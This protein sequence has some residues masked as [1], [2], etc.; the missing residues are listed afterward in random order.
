MEDDLE[1]L[2]LIKTSGVTR[3]I[4]ERRHIIAYPISSKRI[5]NISTTQPDIDFAIS[6]SETC[7]TKGSKSIML[8]GLKIST[9]KSNL[10][11]HAP[12]PTWARGCMALVGDACHL[13]LPRLTQ[14]AAQ[15]LEDERWWRCVWDCWRMDRGRE[16]VRKKRAENAVELAA[17]SA[18]SRYLGEGKLKE[19]RDGLL[20]GLR[21]GR[22]KGVPERWAD[23]EVRKMVCGV[24]CVGIARERFAEFWGE[25]K[26]E[27]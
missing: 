14:G 23:R 10:R 15:A 22:G 6:P 7:T 12:L 11:V 19:E 4:G 13:T 17:P 20:R 3:Q 2:E 21:E 16:K 1:F 26:S 9:L 5:Y 25:V 8:K 27:E 18:R 24:D